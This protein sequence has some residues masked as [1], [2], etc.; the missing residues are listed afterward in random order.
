MPQKPKSNLKG[1]KRTIKFIS[2]GPDRK[3][4][5]LV[6][7]HA[8][9]SVIRAICKAARNAREGDVHIP[10]HLKKIFA[11]YHQQFDKLIDPRFPIEK[12]RQLC[13]KHGGFLPIIPAI[14]GTVLG[15]IGSDFISRIF[16]KN[17]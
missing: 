3:I 5:P 11:R 15:S 16:P 9:I 6:I 12:K 2:I 17:E 8:L 10:P 7:R 13:L 4:L 14:L 1:V